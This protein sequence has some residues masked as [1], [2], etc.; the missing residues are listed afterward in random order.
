MFEIGMTDMKKAHKILITLSIL[1][2]ISISSRGYCQENTM[3]W[4]VGEELSYRVKWSFIRLGTI[5]FQI[6]DSIYFG[7]NKAY[8]IRLHIDSNPLLFWVN[9]HSVFET[10]FSSDFKVYLFSFIEKINDTTYK[11]EYKFDHSKKEVYVQ[12]TDTS[13]VSNVIEKTIPFTGTLLDGTSIFY[14]A[15]ANAGKTGTDTVQYL[16]D[17]DYDRVIINFLAEDK[18]IKI[19][20]VKKKIPSYYLEGQ[21][22]NKGIAG[23]TGKFKGWFSGDRYRI[24]LKAKLKVF[25][26]SVVLELE[27]MKQIPSSEIWSTGD[28]YTE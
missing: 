17:Y 11:A 2:L 6:C 18:K 8:H 19:K 26:G 5:K 3:I 15:R 16:A 27:K 24:P 9:H 28:C 21:I 7:N 22:Q 10:Y 20:A 13:D 12:M 14:Y 25:I 1:S 23:L 4:R